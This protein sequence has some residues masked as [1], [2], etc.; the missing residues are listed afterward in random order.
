MTREM[1]LEGNKVKTKKGKLIFIATISD[2]CTCYCRLAA[3]PIQVT[4]CNHFSKQVGQGNKLLLASEYDQWDVLKPISLCPT[5]KLNFI[6][7]LRDPIYNTSYFFIIIN[8]H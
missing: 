5:W 8:Y 7:H 2:Y 6:P 3:V 1:Q 4:G